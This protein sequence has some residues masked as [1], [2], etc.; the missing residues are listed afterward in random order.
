LTVILFL[1]VLFFIYASYEILRQKK[2]SELQKD[3]IDN[4][5]HEFK[6][7][8]TNIKISAEVLAADLQLAQQPRLKQYSKIITEQAVHLDKQV[9]LILHNAMWRKKRMQLRKSKVDLNEI[10]NESIDL[11]Q[12]RIK[13]DKIVIEKKLVNEPLYVLADVVHLRNLLQN[14]LENAIKYANGIPDIAI[15][16]KLRNNAIEMLVKD[17][18]IGIPKYFQKNIF[19][20]FFRVP[21]GNLHNIKGFGLGLFYVKRVCHAHGWSIRLKSHTGSGTSIFI[22]IPKDP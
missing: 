19:S 5:T 9:D 12:L 13:S 16:T 1:A 6:T 20:P 11:V 4:M 15:E 7:P 18:G 2:L 10:I 17:K 3:F 8:L 14:I 22:G 21:T